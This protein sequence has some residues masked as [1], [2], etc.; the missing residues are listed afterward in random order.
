MTPRERMR[1]DV[2]IRAVCPIV[3]TSGSLPTIR[4]DYNPSASAQQQADA[5]AV[6]QAFD[7]SQDAQNAWE[8]SRVPERKYL[9]DQAAQA[10][11]DLDAFLALPSPTNPQIL[12]VIKKL[13]QQNKRIIARLIQVD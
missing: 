4:I 8:T 1:L 10:I 7:W 6:V 12:A 2:A 3:G 13:C 5:Q 11:A 9:R